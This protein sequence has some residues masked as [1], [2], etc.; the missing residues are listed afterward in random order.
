MLEEMA[1]DF[2]TRQTELQSTRTQL[3]EAETKLKHAEHSWANTVRRNDALEAELRKVERHTSSMSQRASEDAARILQ[4]ERELERE[5][6]KL[7][8]NE[9]AQKQLEQLRQQWASMTGI[10]VHGTSAPPARTAPRTSLPSN[11]H[12]IRRPSPNE[13]PR[14]E[15]PPPYR[16]FAEN[17]Q[18]IG[19]QSPPRML[20]QDQSL[21]SNRT[22]STYLQPVGRHHPCGVHAWTDGAL[23]S[24]YDITGTW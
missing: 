18:I 7:M 13:S 6:A 21:H 17:P 8:L 15:P 14:E 22:S 24:S 2:E 20:I 4:L 23:C 11:F 3:E 12:S 10:L 16:P 19:D 9:D 5:K 1:Q